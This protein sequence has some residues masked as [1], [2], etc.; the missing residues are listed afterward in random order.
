M[1]K[2]SRRLWGEKST[3]HKH[4]CDPVWGDGTSARDIK[5]PFRVG[6]T[7]QAFA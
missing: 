3:T 4:N 7:Q 1:L 2:N 6:H 5:K